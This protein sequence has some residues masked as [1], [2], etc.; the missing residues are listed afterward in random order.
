MNLLIYYCC[1]F[2]YFHTK[3]EG[4]SVI[5]FPYSY[6]HNLYIYLFLLCYFCDVKILVTF[7]RKGQIQGNKVLA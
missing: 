1:L 5:I 6:L 3:N 2:N 7:Y 4:I